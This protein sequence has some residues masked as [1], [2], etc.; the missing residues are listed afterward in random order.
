MEAILLLNNLVDESDPDV[1]ICNV[2]T[3][4]YCSAQAQGLFGHF[5]AYA[6]V[7]SDCRSGL[8]FVLA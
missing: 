2:D 4:W 1:S 8:T 6:A 3:A 7:Q 5:A